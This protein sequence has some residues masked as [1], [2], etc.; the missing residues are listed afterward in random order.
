MVFFSVLPIIGIFLYFY[1]RLEFGHRFERRR[2]VEISKKSKN[3]IQTDPMIFEEMKT[4]NDSKDL[5]G[6]HHFVNKI[7]TFPI[8]NSSQVTY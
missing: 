3:Q 8:Y 6:L 2:L 5:Q 1:T 4:L 7:E